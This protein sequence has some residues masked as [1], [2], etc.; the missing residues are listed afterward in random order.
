MHRLGNGEVQ[1]ARSRRGDGAADRG[2]RAVRVVRR[3]ADVSED[4]GQRVTATVAPSA[5]CWP[6]APTSRAAGGGVT[7]SSTSSVAALI[8][9]ES[10]DRHWRARCRGDPCRSS[11][12]RAPRHDRR[13]EL[14]DT[15]QQLAEGRRRAADRVHGALRHGS[16]SPGGARPR[17]RRRSRSRSP[18]RRRRRSR[19]RGGSVAT[20]PV[21]GSSRLV[22]GDPM[23][24]ISDA[25]RG[26]RGLGSAHRTGPSTGWR[27]RS[28]RSRPLGSGASPTPTTTRSRRSSARAGPTPAIRSSRRCRQRSGAGRFVATRPASPTLRELGRQHQMYL[29]FAEFIAVALLRWRRPGVGGRPA[30]LDLA[31]QRSELPQHRVP[32][33]PARRSG[34]RRQPRGRRRAVRDCSDRV[35]ELGVRASTT[36]RPASP[37]RWPRRRSRWATSPPTCGSSVHRSRGRGRLRARAG[38]ARHLPSAARVRGRRRRIRPSWIRDAPRWRRSTVSARRCSRGCNASGLTSVVGQIGMPSG[39]VRT[40]MFTDIVDSTRLMSSAGNAAWAVILGE[41]HRLVRTVVGRYRGSIMTA[42]GDGF[43]AWFEQP[44]DAADAARALH[45]AIEHAALVVPGGTVQV[46]IGLASGSVFD[47]GADASGMAVAEA[48]RVMSTA[49]PG[50]THVSQIGD[51]SRV[52]RRRSGRS[53][54]VHSL[55][56]LPTSGGDFRAGAGQMRCSSIKDGPIATL[57]TRPQPRGDNRG[58]HAVPPGEGALSPAARGHPQRRDRGGGRRRRR[59]HASRVWPAGTRCWSTCARSW[60]ARAT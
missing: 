9:D 26:S 51:R 27:W 30:A 1:R 20:S 41:H 28:D 58:H 33:R 52:G 11:R 38:H 48:A 25:N 34:P 31:A 55:K 2:G 37:S 29:P 23:A 50:D 3:C 10:I 4:A 56:G 39:R 22:A 36:G 49:G 32:S 24:A 59:D 35:Y 47:L 21:A 15:A 46:R 19:I 40:V 43:S 14:V 54:G 6:C 5:C 45:Q 8:D 57:S 60:L 12:G 53:V 18:T 13:S 7:R 16:A 17:R 44:G 42:T